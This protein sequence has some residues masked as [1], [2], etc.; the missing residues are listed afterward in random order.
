MTQRHLNPE[1][2]RRM[3]RLLAGVTQFAGIEHIQEA[4][5][6]GRTLKVKLGMD[7]TAP[8][9]HLGHAVV[10]RKLRD[11][12]DDGHEAIL[13]VGAFTAQI[14]DP[15]GKNKTR[16]P[17]TAEAVEHNAKTYLEQAFKILDPVKTTVVRND[18][19]LGQLGATGLIQLAAKVTLSQIMVR[20][21]FK[22]RYDA[23]A[24]IAL[25]ELL[26]PLLQ[27][28]DSVHL[29]ADVELGGTDQWFNLHM[30]RA[31]Q[32]KSAQPP[33]AVLV[34]P[35]LVGLDGVHKMSKSLNNHLALSGDPVDTYGRFMSVSDETMWTM[36]PL[37]GIWTVA[38][39]DT[40][41]AECNNGLKNP[42][43]VKMA[44]A[45]DL[46]DMLHG[47]DVGESAQLAFV[48]RHVHGE[49][50]E[51]VPEFRAV[52]DDVYLAAVLRDAGVCKSTADAARTIEQGGVRVNGAVAEKGARLGVGEHYVTVGKRRALRLF[53]DSQDST[54]QP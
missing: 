34:M 39:I 42:M 53:I 51:D 17:L 18:T 23:Q 4:I 12:Q 32:E 16:P 45:R 36:L 33:Q 46:V 11:F 24:P 14:G 28:M 21:D 8:D 25:H 30:G 20:D 22:T 44:A 38:A 37:M 47:P 43:H 3:D 13:I 54:P 48:N 1:Q 35:L 40:A 7:P 29:K 26:Y 2:Q 10:L 9:L 15:T 31:L 50:V 19:W 52:G 41:L 6:T 5:A 27:G 49:K